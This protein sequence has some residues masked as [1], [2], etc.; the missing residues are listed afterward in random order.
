MIAP[1][2]FGCLLM[3]WENCGTGASKEFRFQRLHWQT[4]IFGLVWVRKWAEGNIC[5]WNQM[6]WVP[7]MCFVGWKDFCYW[8]SLWKSKGCCSVGWFWTQNW[9]GNSIL[10]C[11]LH[12]VSVCVYTI[13]AF[14]FIFW[15]SLKFKG[16]GW[17]SWLLLHNALFV[18]SCIYCT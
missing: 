11:Q 2:C 10:S 5:W 13:N 6:C 16:S 9:R 8:I 18:I 7:E 15:E 17:A 14:G 12:F 3:V 4:H 1:F